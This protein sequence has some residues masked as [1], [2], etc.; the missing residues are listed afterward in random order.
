M[1]DISI[2]FNFAKYGD[3]KYETIFYFISEMNRFRYHVTYIIF[4][5]NISYGYLLVD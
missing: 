3:L 2:V 1:F 5:E 4:N